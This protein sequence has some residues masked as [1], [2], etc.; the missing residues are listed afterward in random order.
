MS[1][2]IYR[3]CGCRNESGKAYPV[4]PDKPTAGQITRA[5]PRLTADKDHGSWGYYISAGRDPKTGKRRQARKIGFPNVTVARQARNKEAVKVD[6]GAY[7]PPSKDTLA[8]YLDKWLPRYALTA[9]R[10]KGLRQTT[11]EQ[12]ARYI[13]NDI[14]GSPLA[15]MKLSDIRRHHVVR[16]FDELRASGRGVPTQHQVLKKIRAAFTSAVDDQL[17]DS[18]PAARIPM[19]AERPKTFEA[20][21]A[22]QVGGFLDVAVKH[23]LGALFEL[24]FLSGLRRGELVGL[25][26]SEVNLSS[27]TL[28]ISS[29]RVQTADGVIE[30]APKTDA[31]VRVVSLDDTA[32]GALIAWKLRQEGERDDWGDA[33]ADSGFVFTYE[34]GQPLKPDYA[35]R[36]FEKLRVKAKLPKI[37]L[38][39]TRHEHASMWVDAGGDITLLSKRLGHASIRITSDIYTH[40]IGDA[41]RA[42]AE[43]VASL[44]PRRMTDAHKVHTNAA[45]SSETA[46]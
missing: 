19:E 28:R 12:Y 9:N 43:Q 36:L 27:R 18:N 1:A 13:E 17:I 41:D 21:T 42:T 15:A 11:H 26:W 46:A 25:K 31:G 4:L 20:W 39:G 32:T 8:D 10:G 45:I 16:F 7:L 6:Q 24:A 22:G 2:A 3:R 23:R 14:K 40:R 30:G 29:I 38:H 33:Y 34:D 44:I 5:C 35:T 37:T